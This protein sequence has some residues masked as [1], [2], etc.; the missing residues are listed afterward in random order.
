M[1]IKH[2]FSYRELA[3]MSLQGLAFWAQALCEFYQEY[4]ASPTEI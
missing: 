1:M 3:E 4:Q 2:G